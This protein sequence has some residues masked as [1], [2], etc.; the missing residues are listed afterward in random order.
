LLGCKEL[1][2][3][4]EPASWFTK[5]DEIKKILANHLATDTTEKWLSILEPADIWCANVMDW[6]TLFAQ[7]GFKVLE[8]IQ[9]VTM[10]D[11]FEYETTRCPIKIDGEYLTS[12][13]GSPMLG[14]HT[15]SIVKELIES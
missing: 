13:L 12:S 2:N 14:E 4:P 9:K 15:N 3:Y 6:E 10:G 8:M 11:G 1:T 7:D 5:R